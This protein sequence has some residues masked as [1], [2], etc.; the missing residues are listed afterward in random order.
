LEY[1]YDDGDGLGYYSDGVK[2]TLTDAQIEMFRWSEVQSL[3]RA[4]RRRFDT[5]KEGT[6]NT[7]G[8]G[9]RQALRKYLP[10][11]EGEEAGARRNLG[12]KK[13]GWM[14]LGGLLGESPAKRAARDANSAGEKSTLNYDDTPHIQSRLSTKTASPEDGEDEEEYE[15]FLVRE[16]E[17][18]IGA[19]VST[20]DPDIKGGAEGGPSMDSIFAAD[21]KIVEQYTSNSTTTITPLDTVVPSSNSATHPVHSRRRIFYGDDDSS[22]VSDDYNP[23]K[24]TAAVAA[25]GITKGEKRAFLWPKIGGE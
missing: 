10:S 23:P 3:L 25:G 24:S 9:E 1:D 22:A 21:S 4:K 7:E 16:R 8:N 15:R 13:R 2:R 11:D 17:E 18:L 19:Q 6:D 20:Q 12:S 5:L 14:G